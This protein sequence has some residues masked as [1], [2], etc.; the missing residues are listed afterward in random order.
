MRKSGILIAKLAGTAAILGALVL[1]AGAQDSIFKWTQHDRNRSEPP[2]VTPGEFSTQNHPGAPPSDAIV[3]FDGKDLANW[4]SVKL[5]GK[6]G[7]ELP[8]MTGQPAP[9]SVHDGY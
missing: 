1:L 8:I 7:K 5:P 9:W 6:S 4:E 2:V 3:L